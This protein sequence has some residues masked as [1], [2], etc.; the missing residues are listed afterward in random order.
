MEGTS[1]V[2]SSLKCRFMIAYTY[3]NLLLKSDCKYLLINKKEG[4][5]SLIYNLVILTQSPTLIMMVAEK[6]TCKKNLILFSLKK[7]IF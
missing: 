1:E 6:N 2:S 4:H 7:M 5:L 3:R